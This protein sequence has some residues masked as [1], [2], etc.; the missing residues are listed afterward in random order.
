[1]HVGIWFLFMICYL[2]VRIELVIEQL[3]AGIDTLKTSWIWQMVM[4]KFPWKMS[5]RLM[6]AWSITC[7]NMLISL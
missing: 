3:L 1:M 2:H 5:E 4:G 7:F 6:H